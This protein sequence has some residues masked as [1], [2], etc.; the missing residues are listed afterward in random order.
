MSTASWSLQVLGPPYQR[1]IPFSGRPMTLLTQKISYRCV[2]IGSES[3]IFLRE[4][5]PCRRLV[6]R[7]SSTTSEFF[8]FR[9]GKEQDFSQ[10]TFEASVRDIAKVQKMMSIHK[11]VD[12]LAEF[13]RIDVEKS[14][15][16]CTIKSNSIHTLKSIPTL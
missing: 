6:F 11:D 9:C 2:Q 5:P 10:H 8:C 15:G 3:P 13:K 1:E 4:L 7:H 12:W 14:P 16:K